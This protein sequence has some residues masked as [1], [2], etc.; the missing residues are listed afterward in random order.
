MRDVTV[1]NSKGFHTKVLE[2]SDI[3]LENLTIVAP[4]DSPNTDGVHISRSQ[5]VNVTNT[6]IGTGDDCISVGEGNT[7]VG[8]TQVTCG[9][10]HGIRY[11]NIDSSHP[12]PTV[13]E[14]SCAEMVFFSQR[15]SKFLI[16][17][18]FFFFLLL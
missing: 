2:S 16:L 11:I 12:K 10:G 6:V 13:L 7:N 5:N 8:I 17:F 18:L 3:K 15:V 14:V 1:L 4:E 9:P